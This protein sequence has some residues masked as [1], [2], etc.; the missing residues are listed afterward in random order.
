VRKVDAG[1]IPPLLREN[2]T[3]WVAVLSAGD[4]GALRA[5]PSADRWSRLEYA[6]HVR[7][8]FRRFD[9]RLDVMLG[10]EDPS[11]ANWDQDATAVA[12]HYNEQDPALVTVELFQAGSGLA[13]RF[14]RVTGHQ[15]ERVGTRSDGARF[16]VESLGRY[17]LHDVVHHLVDVGARAPA[18]DA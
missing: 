8:V 1:Q 13:D 4:V 16:N 17:L 2:A 5:R 18:P 6:C 12:G 15:W 10:T 3:V 7:D 14:A 11:F 9:E